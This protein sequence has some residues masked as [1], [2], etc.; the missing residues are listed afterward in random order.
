MVGRNHPL[1]PKLGIL[2]S[3]WNPISMRAGIPSSSLPCPVSSPKVTRLK[4]RSLT[5]ET[6]FG[7][8]LKI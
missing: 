7:Y 2:L 1:C 6:R 8:A 4:R 3:C 5:R